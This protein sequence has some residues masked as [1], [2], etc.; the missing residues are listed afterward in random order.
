[1]T[2]E[3]YDKC[4][5]QTEY[6]MVRCLSMLLEELPLGRGYT[7]LDL[8]A[9]SGHGSGLIQRLFQKDGGLGIEIEVFSSN[10]NHEENL[11]FNEFQWGITPKVIDVN[12]DHFLDG[13]DIVIASHMI[14]HT[15]NPHDTFRNIAALAKKYFII[16]CPYKE[17]KLYHGSWWHDASIDGTVLFGIQ[18]PIKHKIVN[19]DAGYPYS[20]CYYG[21]YRGGV[22]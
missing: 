16:A 9:R 1:M 17:Q 11:W 20:S 12:S 2:I 19:A 4:A 8:G 7:L 14:E 18:A 22:Q 3:P 13:F 21:L 5:R 15:K 6:F 10:F